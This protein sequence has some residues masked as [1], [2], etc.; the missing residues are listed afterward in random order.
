[1]WPRSCCRVCRLE[2]T[3]EWQE[4]LSAISDLRQGFFCLQ[5]LCSLTFK[6]TSQLSISTC[7]V[8]PRFLISKQWIIYV[9]GR[10]KQRTSNLL[11]N[12]W[13]FLSTLSL[14]N[15]S[16][17]KNSHRKWIREELHVFF[18]PSS[19]SFKRRISRSPPI[20]VARVR[21]LASTP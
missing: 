13:L 12:I 16:T 8:L 3:F 4:G 11:E 7:N 19:C 21:I 14:G 10:K 15:S 9:L 1:M 20:N 6:G 5:K 17:S 18:S 2:F